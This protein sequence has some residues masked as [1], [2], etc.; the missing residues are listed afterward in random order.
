MADD[1]NPWT[2]DPNQTDQ[3]DTNAMSGAPMGL[4]E[5]TPAQAQPDV[6]DFGLSVEATQQARR[7][8]QRAAPGRQTTPMAVDE[9][10]NLIPGTGEQG[11]QSIK[12][13]LQRNDAMPDDQYDAESKRIDPKGEMP[14][15]DR[16]LQIIA[17]QEDP[18]QK[19]AGIQTGAKRFD[20]GRAAARV[21]SDND[22]VYKSVEF[23]QHASDYVPKLHDAQF[24]QTRD[25]VVVTQ[26]DKVYNLNNDQWKS[27]LHSNDSHFDMLQRNGLE[28]AMGRV[29]RDRSPIGAQGPGSETP[30][31]SG[32][33][34]GPTEEQLVGARA[35]ARDANVPVPE[36]A[37][38]PGQ[39]GGRLE[40]DYG[41][42]KE[43][44]AP[45]REDT[46]AAE[47]PRAKGAP[48]TYPAAR[49][50]DQRPLPKTVG[51][52]RAQ[53]EADSEANRIAR[54][55]IADDRPADTRQYQNM[56][57]GVRADLREQ[58]YNRAEQGGSDQV[59]RG[60]DGNLYPKIAPDFS[61]VGRPGGP[62][63]LAMGNGPAAPQDR[64]AA[65]DRAAAGAP[66]AP[67]QPPA[68]VQAGA[69]Q[70]RRQLPAGTY[71]Q[72]QNPRGR[73]MFI[74]DE[75]HPGHG[76]WTGGE[77]GPQGGSVLTPEAAAQAAGG[78]RPQ[79][80]GYA[81]TEQSGGNPVTQVLTDEQLKTLEKRSSSVHLDK[82]GN[83][84]SQTS[85]S[86]SHRDAKPLYSPIAGGGAQ[87]GRGGALQ[88]EPN[89]VTP[90]QA[91]EERQTIN[92]YY[93]TL[94]E[95]VKNGDALEPQEK[96]DYDAYR[97]HAREL[98]QRHGGGQQQT[99]APPPEALSMLKEGA[100]TR[101]NNGQVW[102]LRGGKPVR[103]Q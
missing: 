14:V 82:Y 69:Q 84:R 65:Y 25:G 95:K 56:P 83:T 49:Q 97:A 91:A 37:N 13:Y 21:A 102:T 79:P 1:Q 18:S 8:Q 58:F 4:P 100:P 74:P 27:F 20:L 55:S 28:D 59:F 85:S 90:S 47:G 57:P 66:P 30:D 46:P 73:G 86:E 12:G 103:V 39:K 101:F 35:G 93:N 70:F 6:G 26:G 87:Q 71:D 72:S 33:I 63:A 34:T 89:A 10:G 40:E 9:M 78:A 24:T 80:Y 43:Q 75:N 68:Q 29:T 52:A 31:V 98:M 15:K 81:I 22:H 2:E 92:N 94:H 50:Q 51:E 60:P 41:P 96:A 19:M 53:Q 62:P 44:I 99:E 38:L 45:G 32:S 67:A 48:P 61:R 76:A 36:R 88:R 77:E 5:P 11:P 16:H 17:N 7:E 42:T 54:G 3:Q 64:A 23:M